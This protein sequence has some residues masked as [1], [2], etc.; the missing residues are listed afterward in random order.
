MELMNNIEERDKVFRVFS[1]V[2]SI[3]PNKKLA[4]DIIHM[5]GLSFSNVATETWWKYVKDGLERCSL[6]ESDFKL[7][8]E[9]M[10]ELLFDERELGLEVIKFLRSLEPGEQGENLVAIKKCI[11]EVLEN[12]GDHL[13]SL[14]YEIDFGEFA[15]DEF[16]LL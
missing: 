8:K 11:H 2:E 10:V 13:A 7:V 6:I 12:L 9:Y 1:M 15:I 5:K 4:R 14:G 16:R 3:C